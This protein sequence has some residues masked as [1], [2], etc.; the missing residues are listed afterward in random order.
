MNNMELKRGRL[1][2]SQNIDLCGLTMYLYPQRMWLYFLL[3]IQGY[4]ITYI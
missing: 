3:I 2:E 1:R 4:N